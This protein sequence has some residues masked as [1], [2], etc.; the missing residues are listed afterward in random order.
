MSHLSFACRHRFPDGFELDVAFE[1]DRRVTSL[2]GRSGS[3]KSS[4]LSILAGLFNAD[5]ARVQLGDRVIADTDQKLFTR[6]EHRRIGFVFQDHLLFPHMTV[7]ANLNYGAARESGGTDISYDR[8]VEV[9]E[10]RELLG[11]RVDEFEVVVSE[12]VQATVNFPAIF[13]DVDR[14]SDFIPS[15]VSG[16]VRR[17]DGAI[18]IDSA[19]PIG[20]AVNGV[21]AGITQTYDFPVNGRQHAWDVIIDPQL[22]I[23]G[24]NTVEVFTIDETE[25]AAV[26][27]ARVYRSGMDALDA[28]LIQEGAEVLWNVTASGFYRTEWAGDQPF[29]WT[30]EQASLV[31][32]V[33]QGAPPSELVVKVLMTGPPTKNVRVS[34]NECNLFEGQFRGRWNRTFPLSGCSLGSD[35]VEVRLETE[36]HQPSSNDTRELGLAVHAIEL[37]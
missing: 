11:R 24:A 34:V 5:Y 19:T 16:A 6:P 4:I 21:L 33:D 29:R 12:D 10:L 18:D 25:T 13:A 35:T 7:D 9:L 23:D 20:V 3:G 26:V 14:G 37:H 15:H 32:P 17:L 8:V 31:V 22:I 2:F 36:T 27:L 30:E 28:N 1:C